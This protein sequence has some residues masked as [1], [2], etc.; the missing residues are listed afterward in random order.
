MNDEVWVRL[1]MLETTWNHYEISNE[2]NM[3]TVRKATGEVK[4]RKLSTNSINL[5]MIKVAGKT[6]YIHKLKKEVSFNE[7]M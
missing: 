7:L 3:R 4:T 2:D 6:Y 5:P 1:P